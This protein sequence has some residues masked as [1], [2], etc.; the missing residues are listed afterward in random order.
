MFKRTVAVLAFLSI[1]GLNAAS[2]QQV[3]A[4]I[5]M[6]IAPVDA[7][8]PGVPPQKITDLVGALQSRLSKLVRLNSFDDSTSKNSVFVK[9]QGE[10]RD[11]A[12]SKDAADKLREAITS[13]EG[14]KFGIRLSFSRARLEVRDR[15]KVEEKEVVTVPPDNAAKAP[16]RNEARERGGDRLR[17]T[18]RLVIQVAAD[19][20]TL[21]EFTAEDVPLLRV[22]DDLAKNLQL[23]FVLESRYV[24]VPVFV[25]LRNVTVDEALEAMGES[26]R[27]KIERRGKYLVFVENHSR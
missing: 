22:M 11:P 7:S 8:A 13:L 18:P 14:D 5:D 19:G 9:M 23:S 6:N 21:T 26:L 2:A 27:G 17:W 4:E 16:P 1:G 15:E 12:T 10:W 24:G 3:K 20:K 25:S